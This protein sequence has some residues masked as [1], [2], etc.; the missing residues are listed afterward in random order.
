[1]SRGPAVRKADI[2]RAIAAMTEAGLQ[3]GEIIAMP[4]GGVRVLPLT[5]NPAN[6]H[7]S[8]LEKWEAEQSAEHSPERH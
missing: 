2:A 3:V 4:G 6:D 7:R 5:G 1:M 8:P